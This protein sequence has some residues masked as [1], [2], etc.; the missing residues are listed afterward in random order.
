MFEVEEE[1]EEEEEVEEPTVEKEKTSILRNLAKGFKRKLGE[2]SPE[3]AT[4]SSKSTS[5][6]VGV[7]VPDPPMP[8]SYY[9]Q[10]GTRLDTALPPSS[11]TRDA[12]PPSRLTTSPS[13]TRESGPPYSSSP[14]LSSFENP[15]SPSDPNFE[16][17]RLRLMLNASQE[18]LFLQKQ[19]YE[20]RERR[21]RERFDAERAVY[22]RRIRELEESKK[23]EESKRGEGSSSSR[24]R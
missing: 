1:P 23:R 24:R 14:S 19:H 15:E 4:S 17:Q 12:G 8:H 3:V 20:D 22:D 11:S 6:L 5:R 16:V 7:I 21:E 9:V 18:D 10:L 2:R 13:F